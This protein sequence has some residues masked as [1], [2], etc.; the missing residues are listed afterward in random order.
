MYVDL[1]KATYPSSVKI[2]LTVGGFVFLLIV[3]QVLFSLSVFPQSILPSPLQVL[4][5]FKELYE[6][7]GLVKNTMT[8]IYLNFMGYFEALTIAIPLGFII[9]LTPPLRLLFSKPIDTLRF[10]PLTAVT[11][12]FIA[13]FGIG[14]SMKI[15]FLAFGILVYLLPVIIQRIDEVDDVYLQ[16]VYTLGASKWQTL[17]TIYFPSVL[18]KLS[19]DTRVLVAISWTYIIIAEML[20][21]TGGLG[22]LI[23][24]VGQ[25]QGRIDKVFALLIVIILI[26]FLQDRLFVLLDKLL[27]PFKH[28]TAKA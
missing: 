24:K 7:D 23:F 18:S 27:F 11:G 9:A 17:K 3:W 6:S 10:L 15:H 20:N 21:S 1:R 13:W 12:L 5:A 16:T 14:N 28:K 4:K 26:G 25:R 8:S 2:A 19:D 22:S